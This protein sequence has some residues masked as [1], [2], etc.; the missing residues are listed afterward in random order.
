[1]RCKKILG[2]LLGAQEGYLLN[3][4]T[5]VTQNIL[6]GEILRT[7]PKTQA[8]CWDSTLSVLEDNSR[9]NVLRSV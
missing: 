3:N 5:V 8:A 1:M 6:R 7:S 2:I 4:F 9:G